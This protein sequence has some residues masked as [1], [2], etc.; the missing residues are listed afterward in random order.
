MAKSDLKSRLI[1]ARK[2]KNWTQK[3]LAKV[4]KVNA[5]NVSRWELGSSAPSFEAAVELCKVLG[6]SLDY[7]GG[8]DGKGSSE[9]VVSLFNSKLGSLSDLQKK[10]VMGVLRAFG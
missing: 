4:L 10:A 3:D 7:L 1:S 5:K 9:P 8:L 6:V 2:A